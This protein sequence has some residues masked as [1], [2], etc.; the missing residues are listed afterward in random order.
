M[1]RPSRYDWD[2]KKDICYQLYVAQKKSPKEIVKYFADHFGCSE[3][4]L[5]R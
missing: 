2:D 1:G 4:E 5:P 3:E